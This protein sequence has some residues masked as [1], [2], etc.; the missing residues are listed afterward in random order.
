MPL[1]ALLDPGREDG[2]FL[3]MLYY[4]EDSIEIRFDKNIFR[5]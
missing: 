2:I 3:K 5:R 1:D 4:G